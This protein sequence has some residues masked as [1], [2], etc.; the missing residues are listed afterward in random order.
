MKLRSSSIEFDGLEVVGP[1]AV[2]V[3]GH[4]AWYSTYLHDVDFTND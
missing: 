3:I 2:A 1:L 4:R